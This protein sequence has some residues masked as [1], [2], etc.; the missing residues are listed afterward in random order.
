M[1]IEDYKMIVRGVRATCENLV[2]ENDNHCK[3]YDCSCTDVV[4]NGC[5]ELKRKT[6]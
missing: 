3:A 2:K 1:K 4:P 6:K 5:T